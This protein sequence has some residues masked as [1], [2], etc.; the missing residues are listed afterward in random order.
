[1]QGI[2]GPPTGGTLLELKVLF[3]NTAFFA[4]YLSAAYGVLASLAGKD[5][6]LPFIS[7]AADRQVGPPR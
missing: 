1:V 6:R 5:V 3:N 4:V 7:E 2:N